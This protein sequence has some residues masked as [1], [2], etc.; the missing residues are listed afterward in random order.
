[1][2]DW[3]DNAQ[4][5]IDDVSNVTWTVWGN[6]SDSSYHEVQPKEAKSSLRNNYSD[7][8]DVMTFQLVSAKTGKEVKEVFEELIAA[9]HKRA[10]RPVTKDTEL[11]DLHRGPSGKQS[12]CC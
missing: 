5:Y 1:M 7:I 11:I 4:T 12:K 9:T 2:Q 6:K 8:V 10:Q 3:M